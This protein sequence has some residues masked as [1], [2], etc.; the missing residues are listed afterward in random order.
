MW[1]GSNASASVGTHGVGV[2]IKNNAFV[3]GILFTHWVQ[4]YLSVTLSAG[5]LGGKASSTVSLANVSQQVSSVFPVLLGVRYY[6]L[7]SSAE[8]E[9]RPHLSVAVGPYTGAEVSNTVL[10]Q[11][12]RTETAFGG[13]FGA[14]I[15][16]LVSN[17]FKLGADAGYTMTSDFNPSIGG[18]KNYNGGDF[19]IGIGYLF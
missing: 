17:H 7:G 11:D 4:E 6:F 19:L 18:R 13:R 10:V 16:F 3:G 1:S 5:L 2:E 15:D 14:G 8:G 12:A 9:V